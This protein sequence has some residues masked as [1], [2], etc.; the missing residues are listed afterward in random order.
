LIE[1]RQC[2]SGSGADLLILQDCG[3]TI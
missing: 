3:F 2:G 1:K